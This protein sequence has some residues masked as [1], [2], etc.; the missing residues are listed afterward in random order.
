MFN[1]VVNQLQTYIRHT[2]GNSALVG[3]YIKRRMNPHVVLYSE[4]V[5][6]D[7]GAAVRLSDVF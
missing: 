7:E 1:K 3:D 5:D 4:Y 2:G 6:G